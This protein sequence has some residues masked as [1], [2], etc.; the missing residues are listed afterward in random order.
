MATDLNALLAMN[1]GAGSFM[2]GQQNQS[3]LASALAH[4]QELQQL[5]RAREQQQAFDAQNQPGLLQHQQLVN[6]GL[7]ADNAKKPVEL[8]TAQEALDYSR[9][10]NPNLLRE[11]AA[12]AQSEEDKVKFDQYTRANAA[13]LDAG[14]ILATTPPA[15]RAQVLRDH[16][17]GA[18]LNPDAPHFQAIMN[19]DANQMP[20]TVAALADAVGKQKLKL[21]PSAQ[22]HIIASENAARASNY[23][24]DK[25]AS[26][27]LGAASIRANAKK[28]ADD[29]EATAENAMKLVIAGKMG[30]DKALALAGAGA[31]LATSD[32]EKAAWDK[33]G[34]KLQA[35]KVEQQQAR[36]AG[37]LTVTPE[38]TVG[39]RKTTPAFGE[40]SSTNKTK[41]GVPYKVI[42]E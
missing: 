32:E 4:Q 30:V 36:G 12:K 9:K 39:T 16:L 13:L 5:I 35:I 8:Q 25:M 21:D 42:T 1:P 6:E 18:G 28:K 17:K 14:P 23:H 26:A 29:V 19:M 24:A 31:T 22:A 41:S 15:L 10:N 37:G 38:G 20:A 27:T 7:S 33:F 2:I 11:N 34:S 3:D 40:G